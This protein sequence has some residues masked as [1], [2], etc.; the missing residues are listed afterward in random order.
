MDLLSALLVNV[1]DTC[2]KEMQRTGEEIV[3]N[4]V[5]FRIMLVLM[6]MKN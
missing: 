1:S 5:T 3:I 4:D 2:A 6:M